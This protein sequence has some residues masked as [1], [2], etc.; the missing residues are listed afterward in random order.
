MTIKFRL[1]DYAYHQWDVPTVIEIDDSGQIDRVIGYGDTYNAERIEIMQF[2]GVKDSVGKEI[3]EGDIVTFDTTCGN[4]GNHVVKLDKG[5]FWPL[6][7]ITL[8]MS[9]NLKVIGNLYENPELVEVK[10]DED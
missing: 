3:Y 10:E 5:T 9:R 7:D 6:D 8:S 2:S 4:A 1:W